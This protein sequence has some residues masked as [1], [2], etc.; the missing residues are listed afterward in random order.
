MGVKAFLTPE[1]NPKK[2]WIFAVEVAYAR[3]QAYPSE[4]PKHRFQNQRLRLWGAATTIASVPKIIFLR[5][6]P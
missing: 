5:L 6:C 2:G 4:M 1:W 3:L